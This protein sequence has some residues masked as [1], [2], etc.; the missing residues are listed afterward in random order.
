M[1]HYLTCI[2]N[3][4]NFTKGKNY[5][6]LSAIDILGVNIDL[7]NGEFI[8][9]EVD[10][11]FVYNL[12]QFKEKDTKHEISVDIYCLDDNNK[13]RMVV[14][15]FFDAPPPSYYRQMKIKTLL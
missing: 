6:I 11:T 5:K 10:M 2:E 13:M 14:K 9:T 3:W 12:I 1:E 15:S 8:N 4:E 7:D